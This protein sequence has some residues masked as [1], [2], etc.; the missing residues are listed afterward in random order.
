MQFPLFA[1][2]STWTPPALS[3]L[4]SWA[5]SK[6]VAVDVETCDPQL[7][8][9]GVGVRRDGYVTGFSVAIED[10]PAFYLPIRHAGGDNVECVATALRYMRE[11]AAA[12]TGDVVGANLAYDLDYME[13]EG[14]T[15][16]NTRYFR[17]IQIADPLI[18]ELH[19]SFSLENIAKRHNLPGKEEALLREAA[20]DYKV[21]PKK[22]MWQLPARY[23]G[24]YAEEDARRPLQILRRQERLIEED[25]LWDIWNLES[26]VL[27]VLV[28]MRR[29][30]VRIDFDRLDK[31][32]LWAL[33]QEKEALDLVHR[34]TGF[35][36]GVGD[37]WKSELLAAPLEHIGIRLNKT[38]A[39]KKS[40]DKDALA[41][42]DHPVAKALAWARKTNKLRTT[43]AASVRKYQVNGRIHCTF[44]Q[45]AREDESG[46][47]RGAR[48]GRLSCVD[49][50]L[51]QQPSRDEF[52]KEWRSIYIPEEGSLWASNDYS[53]QE[54]RWTTHFAAVMNLPGARAAAQAYHDDPLLDN[55]QFMADLTGLP[56]KFAKNV[57]LGLCYGE[58]GAKLSQDLGLP[59]RFAMA[60]GRGRERRV[61]YFPTRE[62]AVV[63]RA[64][65]GDGYVFE[66]AGEEGQRVID[67][68][69]A[70]APFIRR[71]A[72]EAEK[73]AKGRGYILTGG[74][75]RLHFPQ[76]AD[77]SFDWAHKALNRLIQGT[78]ADQ[79]KKAIVALDD[80]G[81][82]LQLQVHD[83]IN[84]SVSSREEAEG[85]AA[86]MRDVMPAL[87]PF[88]VDVEIGDSWG[89]SMG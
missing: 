7:K 74:N 52:A 21:D 6:R 53:Q 71:L 2:V 30:G 4:P 73:K 70:R 65:L 32:E 28:K 38:A 19:D 63:A 37:V 80:L 34:E 54:P 82:Y 17:D 61:E 68:F 84:A 79:V 57:Y 85:M 72:Q 69:D 3:S 47:Q 50:N 86:V 51:Q 87:V 24:K 31:I 48:Y 25:D 56:R 43:F 26:K 78:S 40:V 11:N 39:G 77:G 66:T 27:P 29:R 8:Q 10:G 9:L 15:F 83:E 5:G 41:S 88:R 89:G 55:H 14:V 22:G 62:E 42:I 23:V 18:Y 58:G 59:T 64:K 67:T 81:H 20:I 1:P 16:N 46:D 44:N 13:Q 49:P 33:N 76:K 35:R 75:R 12:F 36:V 45:I 60:S